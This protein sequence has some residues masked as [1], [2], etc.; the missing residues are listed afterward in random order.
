MCRL[1][2][3]DNPENYRP[4]NVVTEKQSLHRQR[5]FVRSGNPYLRYESA[6]PDSPP[7]VVP[8]RPSPHNRACETTP[9]PM[10]YGALGTCSAFRGGAATFDD[11][12][13]DQAIAATISNRRTL[14]KMWPL[15]VPSTTPRRLATVQ[16]RASEAAVSAAMKGSRTV[17]SQ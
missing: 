17:G 15:T 10:R 7:P 8:P 11:L 6:N 14:G 13:A 9:Q 16:E 1:T 3:L 4:M 5:L 2:A 12:A